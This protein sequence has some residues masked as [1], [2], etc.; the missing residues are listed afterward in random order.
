MG[1][2]GRREEKK[3]GGARRSSPF[4]GLVIFRRVPLAPSRENGKE[5]RETKNPVGREKNRTAHEKRGGIYGDVGAR[6]GSRLV[7]TIVFTARLLG[8]IPHHR[9]S[10]SVRI[11]FS[12]F[13]MFLP[14]SRGKVR[15]DELSQR[16]P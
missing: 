3:K 15:A 2:C 5:R 9:H 13:L 16:P 1:V 14:H 8:F 7:P 11:D 4:D 6:G 10:L 12:G